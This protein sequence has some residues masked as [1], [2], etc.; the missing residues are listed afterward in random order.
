MKV[1]ILLGLRVRSGT[2]FVGTTL[3]QH[4]DIQTIPPTSSSG[5]FN[6][7]REE[8]IKNKVFNSIA[9]RSFGSGVEEEDFPAFMEL[10]GELWIKF[11]TNKFNLDENKTLFLKSPRVKETHLWQLAFPNAKIVLLCRDGRDNVISSI[12]ASNDK[13]NWHKLSHKLKKRI[14]YYSGRNFLNFTKDWAE[15]AKMFNNVK[16]TINLRKFKYEELNDSF[17]GVKNLLNFYEIDDSD[18]NVRKC[19]KAPVVGSSYGVD[20]NKVAKPNWKPDFDKSKFTFTRKWGN[21][22]FRQ[23]I[24]FKNIAGDELIKLGYE[25]DN[26]W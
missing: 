26:N 9:N 17:D 15:K 4:P 22:K 7:F 21:W 13:R 14:N 24:I 20:N 18:Y 8:S 25:Q 2:N 10:Y 12:K 3:K 6:L 23:K 16:E 5:E 11:L 19:L 1:I